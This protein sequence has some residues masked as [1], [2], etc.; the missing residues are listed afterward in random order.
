MSNLVTLI[1][2]VEEGI[3]H[4]GVNSILDTKGWVLI[5]GMQSLAEAF[6]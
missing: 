1:L 4:F 3:Q 2:D 5:C 6:Y